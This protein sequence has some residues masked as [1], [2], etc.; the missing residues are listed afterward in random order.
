M[1]RKKSVPRHIPENA[2]K[3][4]L[5]FSDIDSDS[6]DNN[7]NENTDMDID[8]SIHLEDIVSEDEE[9]DK[10]KEED[11]EKELLKIA[12]EFGPENVIRASSLIRDMREERKKHNQ[13]A[14]MMSRIMRDNPPKKRKKNT[15][16]KRKGYHSKYY[17]KNKE[18][19]K[20]KESWKVAK[21]VVKKRVST[22]RTYEQRRNGRYYCLLCDMGRSWSSPS[23]VWY[24]LQSVHG[25]EKRAYRKFK[26][27]VNKRDAEGADLLM[28][29][30]EGAQKEQDEKDPLEGHD[31]EE[32]SEDDADFKD[33]DGNDV[34]IVASNKS[35]KKGGRK[36]TRR[37]KKRTKKKR[38][39]KRSRRRRK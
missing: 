1:P 27:G 6:D 8:S 26:K 35:F 25:L 5:Y 33:D 24:H 11:K 32:L 30:A 36:K 12:A 3:E 7:N 21:K 18:R 9:E 20:N 31:I 23:G 14:K 2:P 39:K 19:W 10:K 16:N 34:K 22:G 38:R 28:G 4:R 15:T 13:T 17:Q 29:F 37:K